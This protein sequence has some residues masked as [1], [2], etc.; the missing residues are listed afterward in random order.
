[1]T[2]IR[3]RRQLGPFIGEETRHEDDDNRVPDHRLFVA[4]SLAAHPVADQAK[5]AAAIKSDVHLL[6]EEFNGHDAAKAV[7]H[8][9]P[10]YVGMFHGMANTNGPAE[11]M[12]VTRQQVADPAANLSVSNEIVDSASA[13]DMAV[14]RAT[15]AFRFTDPATRQPTTEAGNWVMSYKVQPDGS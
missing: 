12:V 11:D 3:V 8:D 14:Y 7:A 6:V 15:D 1:L 9:S 4:G 5:V 2:A 13:G 10:G